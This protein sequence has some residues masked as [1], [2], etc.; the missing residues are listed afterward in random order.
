MA[1]PT[2]PEIFRERIT[3]FLEQQQDKNHRYKQKNFANETGISYKTISSYTCPTGQLKLPRGQELILL[4]KCMGTTTD[5]LLG[6][7]DSK[8]PPDSDV[9]M[10]S[11]YIGLSDTAIEVLH[12]Y[13]QYKNKLTVID[14][15]NF[16]LEQL[17]SRGSFRHSAFECQRFQE[18]NPVDDA[19][20]DFEDVFDE[21][22][23]PDMPDEDFNNW[24]DEMRCL[25]NDVDYHVAMCSMFS[26]HSILDLID[27]FLHLEIPVTNDYCITSDGRICSEEQFQSELDIYDS[28]FDKMI[29]QMSGPGL[30]EQYFLNL[31]IDFLKQAKDTYFKK[32]TQN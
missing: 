8:S 10:I 20:D 1:Q 27:T 29:A 16:L 22:T 24:L 17:A 11:D 31:I 12:N 6:L 4:A 2:A 9:R 25:E 30:A 26:G 21:S 5:Y 32:A 7:T 3:E 13:S 23:I 14:T 19:E 18:E 28:P 15:I